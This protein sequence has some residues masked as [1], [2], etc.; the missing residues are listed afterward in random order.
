[1]WELE[2]SINNC[3]LPYTITDLEKVPCNE[4]FTEIKPFNE[5]T[6]RIVTLSTTITHINEEFNYFL[7]KLKYL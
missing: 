5:A 3:K 4:L 7:M 2:P 1:M 6:N